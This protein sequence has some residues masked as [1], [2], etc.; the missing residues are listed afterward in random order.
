MIPLACPNQD[1]GTEPENLRLAFHHHG[2]TIIKAFCQTWFTETKVG[3]LIYLYKG[4]LRSQSASYSLKPPFITNADIFF[5]AM[6]GNSV[7]LG[8]HVLQLIFNAYAGFRYP[9]GYVVTKEAQAPELFTLFWDAVG[10]LA[11]FGFKVCI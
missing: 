5:A 4:Y 9:L 7:Q 11:E 10:S 8:T 3:L 6:K 1:E 2:P